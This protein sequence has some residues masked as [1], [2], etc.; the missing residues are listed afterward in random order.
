MIVVPDN[1]LS[2]QEA[3]NNA[4]EGDTIFVRSGFYLESIE[5]NKTGL[6]LTGENKHNTIIDG[7]DSG[8]VILVRACKDVEISGFTIQNGFYGI[9]VVIS[10]QKAERIT[11]SDNK[12]TSC[13][14]AIQI[15]DSFSDVIRDNEIFENNLGIVLKR[16]VSSIIDNVTLLNNWYGIKLDNC[17]LHLVPPPGYEKN[18]IIN[19]RIL[20]SDVGIYFVVSM[21]NKIF[22]NNFTGNRRDVVPDLFS[23]NYYDAGYPSGG[24][25]WSKYT[26]QDKYS[27]PYQNETGSDGIG[28]T[29]Y[30]F[31]APDPGGQDNYPLFSLISISVLPDPNALW[32]EPS[33]IRTRVGDRFNITV[34]AYV[35]ESVFTWQTELFFN[36]TCLK[37]IRAG[38][39]AG[40][41]SEFFQGQITIPVSPVINNSEGTILHGETLLGIAE[42]NQGYGSFMWVEFEPIQCAQSSLMINFS[43]PYGEDTFLLNPDLDEISMQT[44]ESCKILLHD[45]TGD[46]NKDGKVDIQD[47]EMVA[48]LFGTDDTDPLYVPSC[49]INNDEK[50]DMRDIGAVARNIIDMD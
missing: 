33:T 29:P 1:Y 37:A 38:Y 2:I 18:K 21:G 41:T 10:R 3:V 46:L 14:T 20:N 43:I 28:D 32:L 31:F 13:R 24:N 35:N 50:I 42:K 6:K 40:V 7:N 19:S 8:R 23:V 30:K 17:W 39:T 34:W 45:L 9:R 48:K 15:E 22:H 25:Y 36:T 12:I 27:G 11:I 26:G 4:H 49:D 5:V 44:I 16:T 47:A